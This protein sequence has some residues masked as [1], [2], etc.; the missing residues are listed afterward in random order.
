VLRLFR[1]ARLLVSA[2]RR[3]SSRRWCAHLSL[4]AMPGAQQKATRRMTDGFSFPD[5]L[6]SSVRTLKHPPGGAASLDAVPFTSRFQVSAQASSRG[7]GGDSPGVLKGVGRGADNI[8]PTSV[9]VWIQ[10][11]PQKLAF[12]CGSP[13]LRCFPSSHR[14]RRFA[15]RPDFR[16]SLRG[17]CWFGPPAH[18]AFLSRDPAA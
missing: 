1:L 8:T 10:Q 17:V 13:I 2:K 15:L 11:Y 14:T 16:A 18:L 12:W 7:F 6:H 4:R 9:D 3:F 5:R